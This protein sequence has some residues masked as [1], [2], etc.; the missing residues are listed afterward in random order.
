VDEI[1]QRIVR[2]ATAHEPGSPYTLKPLI[3]P[4]GDQAP[5]SFESLLGYLDEQAPELAASVRSAEIPERGRRNVARLFGALLASPERFRQAC[6]QPQSVE[7]ALKIAG[8]SEYL[9]GL[10]VHHPEDIGALDSWVPAPPPAE[11]QGRIGI[12]LPSSAVAEPFPWVSEGVFDVREKM[13]LLRRHF[14]ARV[15]E[16][17]ASDLAEMGAIFSCLEHWTQLAGRSVSSSLWIGHEALD[18][19]LKTAGASPEEL[20]FAVL[21]LGRLG[22]SEFDLASDADVIFVAA[23]GTEREEIARWMR[24][25]EKIIEIL[26]SYTRD[27]TLFAVDTRLRP[28][29]QE[30]ELVTTE[31]SLL[32]YVRE[33]AQVWEA[34]TYL[35]ACPIAGNPELGCRAV[36]E[37]VSEVFTRFGNYP[38]LEGELLQMRR[39]LEKEKHVPV[40]NTKS[41][42]GG[43]YDVDFAVSYLRLRY[44]VLLRPGANMAQQIK[45][46]ETA[47]ALSQDDARALGDG[48]AFLRSVDHAIRLVTGKPVDGLPTQV[49]QREAV[50]TLARSW[51]LVPATLTLAQRLWEVQQEVRYVYRRMLGS[52]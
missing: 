40:T 8:S 13:A 42:P 39:R 9:T 18:G 14:R 12:E 51:G 15:L 10:L 45:A 36:A 23:A 35:K 48:A 46:L 1:H 22:L 3:A 30:G 5:H 49:G 24:F 32:G 20:P 11:G 34:L 31:S 17:G 29:G 21:G 25:A 16:L 4:I 47:G 27:G 41:A 6:Q 50:E 37:L 7:S 38:D 2:P 26:S 44:G 19:A 43:Y 52:E 28:R 33:S